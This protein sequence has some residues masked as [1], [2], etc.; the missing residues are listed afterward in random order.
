MQT[1][2]AP[3]N[4]LPA[5]E[6]WCARLKPEMERNL[7]RQKVETTWL[8]PLADW[9]TGTQ[10]DVENLTMEQWQNDY[11]T[12]RAFFTTRADTLLDHLD[13]QLAAAEAG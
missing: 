3:E 12:L 4:I 8:T 9:L 1:T 5:F 7:A 11:E 6:A 2:Y 10:S 13:T